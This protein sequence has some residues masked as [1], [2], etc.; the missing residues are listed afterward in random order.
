MPF[1]VLSL[2]ALSV[3]L[4]FLIKFDSNLELNDPKNL[5]EQKFIDAIELKLTFDYKTLVE[6]RR[7]EVHF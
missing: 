2:L 6:A 7:L 1:R 4:I 3:G 5:L